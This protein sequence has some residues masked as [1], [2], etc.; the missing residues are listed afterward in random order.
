MEIIQPENKYGILLSP[1][2][3]IHRAYFEEMV[4]L[5]GIQVVYYAPRPGKRYTTY[6]EVK[7]N[8][9]QPEVIGVIFD[10][11]PDQK[12][13]KKLGWVAELQEGSSIIHVPYNLHDIQ[14]D[15]LFAIPS[16]LDHTK[17]RLFRVTQLT[18]TMVYPASIACE[19]VPE[20]ENTLPAS[21]IIDQTHHDFNLLRQE[22][23]EF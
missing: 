8:Y 4:K 10:E 6:D 17:G 9:Q 23:D 19:I 20:Y 16:G 18:N 5:M 11:Y 2:I 15:A 22:G 12:S 21:K 13:M 1:D 7:D 3:K 14:K